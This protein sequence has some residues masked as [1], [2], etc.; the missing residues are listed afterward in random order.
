MIT[1]IDR[2]ATHSPSSQFTVLPPP[3]SPIPFSPALPSAVFAES[4]APRVSS[5]YGFVS[6]FEV[7]AGLERAGFSVVKAAQH[8]VRRGSSP[9]HARH[10]LRLRHASAKLELGEYVPEVVIL[11]SHDGSSAYQISIGL[12]R[13]VC[14][15]GLVVGSPWG[16]IRVRHTKFQV[17]AVV[18]ASLELV[19][20]APKARGVVAALQAV[21]LEPEERQAFAEAASALRWDTD[22][23]AVAPQVLLEPRRR[24]DTGSDLWTTYNAV[25]ENIISGGVRSTKGRKTR[26]VNAPSEGVRLNKALWLLAERMAALKGVPLETSPL[27]TTEGM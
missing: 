7:L 24:E 11:N 27:T 15:N 10:V 13:L 16:G 26:G 9:D 6:T 22:A 17:D 21:Q 14:L 3:A 19:E 23:P 12:F 25:Q 8:R 2:P 18:A 20:A 5:R 1:P 4:P